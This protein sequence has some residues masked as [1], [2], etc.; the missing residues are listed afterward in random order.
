[1][2]IGLLGPADGNLTLLREAAEFLLRDCGVDQAVY[3][4]ADDD[5]V[6]RVVERWAQQVMGKSSAGEDAFL[7]EAVELA[8]RG[9]GASIRALLS[10]D[11]QVRRLSALRCL[12]PPP[13]RAVEVFDDKVVLFVHDKSLLDEEDIANAFLVVYGR[14][15]ACALNRFGP[16]TFFTPGP[17]KAGRVAILEPAPDGGL[18][19]AQFNPETGEPA[20]RD[21]LMAR[22]ARL[23]VQS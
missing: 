14:G 5:A 16:R 2:R 18:A 17:L 7:D 15:K 8:V 4:G 10:R 1:M 11:A 13:A 3:L 23:V 19:V 12:P 21:V 22:Q 9:D 20:G 6:E